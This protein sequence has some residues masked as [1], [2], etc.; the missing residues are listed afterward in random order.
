MKIL[1]KSSLPLLLGLILLA[2]CRQALAQALSSAEIDSIADS[3]LEKIPQ[4]GIAVV[5]VKDGKVVH[6]KGYGWASVEEQ[7]PVTE[8]TLFAI[9]SNSK[10]FTAAALAMLVDEGKLDW[11][12]KVVDY[13][14]EFTMY[15]PWVREN[16]T[17]VDL[18]THRSGL[19]LGAGDLMIFPDST[20]FTVDDVLASFQHQKPVSQFRTKYDYDNLLYIVA[21]EVIKRVSGQPWP[22]FIEERILKPIGMEESVASFDRIQHPE[23]IAYPYSSENGELIRIKPYNEPLT[24]PAGGICANVDDL[25]KWLLVLLNEGKYG[26]SLEHTLFTEERQIEMWRPYTNMRFHLIPNARYRNHFVAYGLGWQIQDYCGYNVMSHGGGLP[27]MLSYTMVV[28]ELELGVVVLTN[29]LPGGYAY[30][31]LAQAIVDGYLGLEPRD[32]V[33][34]AGQRLASM[35]H[36]Q[37]SIMDAVWATVEKAE[38]EPG[39]Y[40]NYA[41]WYE[42]PWFGKMEVWQEDDE[43]W[44]RSVRNP[45]LTG[46]MH[47]Y[48]ATTFVVDW[49]YDDMPCEAFAIFG[50]DTEGRATSIKMKGIS[51]FID[52]SYDFQDLDLQRVDQ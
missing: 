28:P 49:N 34:M 42:D 40:R 21:G 47:Y 36:T 12:D 23:L 41:G 29:T 30:Y 15:D 45:K 32:W 11:N 14:P 8:N 5:V 24:D 19:G 10:A 44:I 38:F 20:D 31:G 39:N 27:G 50:L 26:D 4:A 2:G 46:R 16:F 48:Q 51:P 1:I 13:I 17:I 3:Y 35:G 43:L 6:E 18:L 9:A 25:G 22:E 52:F 37:D 33:K 7:I